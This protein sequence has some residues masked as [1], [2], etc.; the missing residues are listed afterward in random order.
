[1]TYQKQL[2]NQCFQTSVG[3]LQTFLSE[4]AHYIYVY[5]ITSYFLEGFLGVCK[6]LM[7]L[8]KHQ[9]KL[10]FETFQKWFWLLFTYHISAGSTLDTKS[11]K[12]L[13]H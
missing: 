8:Y 1:M 3:T 13:I 6:V 4:S 11:D 7:E 2:I 5:I 10:S 9:A 12:N